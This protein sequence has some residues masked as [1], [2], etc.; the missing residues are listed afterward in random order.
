MRQ[1]GAFRQARGSRRV[2]DD[3]IVAAVHD[4]AGLL[5]TGFGGELLVLLGT[6]RNVFATINHD[7]DV[8][9]LVAELDQQILKA[10]FDKKNFVVRVLDDE[11]DLFCGKAPIDGAEDDADLR[12]AVTQLEVLDGIF[13]QNGN[14]VA[15]L[16][17]QLAQRMRGAIHTCV[18]FLEGAALIIEDHRR[19]VRITFGGPPD[20]GAHRQRIDSREFHFVS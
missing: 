13:S 18:V 8:R 7:F 4:N 12:R 19:A 15:L 9:N 17:L 14:V 10:F 3:C 16:D 20:D 1:H 2:H 11:R 6:R 5:R